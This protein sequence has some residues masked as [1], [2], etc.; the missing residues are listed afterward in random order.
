MKDK[1]SVSGII[2]IIVA[3]FGYIMSNTIS[4]VEAVGMR[5][6]F[7][8]KFLFVT[9]GICGIELAYRGYKR[10]FKDALPRI[11]Y[12]ILIP[13][14]AL[15]IAYVYAFEYIGYIPAT[16]V[17]TFCSMYAFGERR[18]KFLILLPIGCALTIYFLFTYVFLIIL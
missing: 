14:I 17:F 18:E 12:H 8:P 15:M 5:E 10:K 2:L 1:D 3:V 7:Y 4:I 11:K 13:F 9:L 6:D 16:I